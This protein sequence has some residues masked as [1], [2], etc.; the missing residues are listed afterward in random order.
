MNE[1]VKILDTNNYSIN[2][3]N[4]YMNLEKINSYYPTFRNLKLLDKLLN[5]INT[6][7]GGAILLSG[8]Y[9]TGKS[10]FTSV[11]MNILD[12]DFRVVNYTNFLKKADNIY[13][14]NENM[15]KFENKKYL[16]V[17]IEDNVSEFSKGLL[18]GINKAVKR[19][20]IK[21]N[22]STQYEIIE[23]KISYWKK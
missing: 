8:A 15:K 20:K 10:Y 6:D 21:L 16:I 1:I 3:K 4:D 9:G 5:R 12:K 23:K 18:L 19:T 11:L 2:V 13:D 7:K 22:L 14:I 17:F